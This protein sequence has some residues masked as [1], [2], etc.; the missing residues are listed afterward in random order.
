MTGLSDLQATNVIAITAKSTE[1]NSLDSLII[2]LFKLLV[3]LEI[4][5]Q[6]KLRKKRMKSKFL[7][8]KFG[9]VEGV[10]GEDGF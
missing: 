1:K 10:G 3:A 4:A 8:Q 6:A 2:L 5:Y 9:K 7:R